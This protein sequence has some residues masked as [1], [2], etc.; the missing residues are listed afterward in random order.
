[1][2]KRLE[3]NFQFI[4]VG[5]GDPDKKN[6]DERTHEYVEIYQPYT[7]DQVADQSHRCLS[8]GNP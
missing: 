4:D 3:N 8:C 6:M 2:S 1:M 5:R 7:Q